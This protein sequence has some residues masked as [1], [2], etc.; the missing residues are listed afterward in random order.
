[1]GGAILIMILLTKGTTSTIIVTLAEKQTI[2]DAN[3]LFVFTSR[4]TNEQVKFVLVTTAD[5][6]TNKERWN[7]FSIVV[8]TYFNSFGEG[9]F[10]YEVYEQASTTNTDETGLTMIE[11]GVAFLSD[12]TEPTITKY[13]NAVTFKTYDAG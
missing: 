7:E 2:T 11:S 3:F 1:M 12:N 13:D 4:I 5:V 10:L 9:W 8:N 6:S